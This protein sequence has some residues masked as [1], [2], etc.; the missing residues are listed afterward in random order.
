MANDGVWGL[1]RSFSYS[2]SFVRLLGLRGG[3]E[4]R[5]EI[6][7]KRKETEAGTE[8]LMSFRQNLAGLALFGETRSSARPLTM[9]DTPH[10]ESWKDWFRQHG[11]RLLLY[12]RQTTRSLADAEDVLQEAFVRFWRNQRGLGGDPLGLV[13]ASIRRAACDLARKNER[14]TRREDSAGLDAHGEAQPA[15]SF[16]EA[17]EGDD[18]RRRAIEQALGQLPAEQR[19]VL[20]LKIWGGRT[21]EQI[22][23]Q[24]DVSPH[25]AASRYRYALEA[26]RKRLTPADCTLP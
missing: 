25:T 10:H 22:G 4:R 14:R 19:E 11:P 15:I 7:R 6:K 16:F 12:A 2:F 23:A 9:E 1:V 18:E 17:A 20:M 21:F 3:A 24:L 13:F 8:F 26:L 5:R